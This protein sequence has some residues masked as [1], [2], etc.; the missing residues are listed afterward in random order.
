MAN[1]IEEEEF[2][3]KMKNPNSWIQVKPREFVFTDKEQK[4]RLRE[5]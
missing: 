2:A 4:M 1:S 5:L 3:T